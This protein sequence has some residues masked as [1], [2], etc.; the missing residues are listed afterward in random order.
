MNTIH[1]I[2]ILVF[3]GVVMFILGLWHYAI[4]LK[5]RTNI[6][7]KIQD[8][9][10]VSKPEKV[11][12]SN[13]AIKDYLMNIVNSLGKLVSSRRRGDTTH[14]RL[15]FLQA[16]YQNIN[17]PVIFFGFKAFLS[18]LLLIGF[19]LIKIIVL[20]TIAPVSFIFYSVMCALIGFYLPN[21]WLKLK[22]ANRKDK[23]QKGFPDALDLM[24]VC[25]EGGMGLDASINRIGEEMKLSNKALSEEFRLL[26]LEMR[27]GKSRREALKNLA[28]RTDVEDVNSL[29][30]LL[31]QTERFGTSIAQA[32]RVHSDFMR[33]KRYQRSEELAAKLP[34]KLIFPLIL[35][36]FPSLLITIL[37]PA[38]IVIV[39]SIFPLFPGK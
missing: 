4:Y 17:A 20:K 23:I 31:I 30:T 18:I 5:E 26:N 9:G 28:L 12:K 2:T 13:N 32:L 38:V 36:I 19:L 27:A 29:V 21:L 15:R 10:K 22:I 8:S 39:R 24:V 1:F 33:T 3:I 11:S 16:G 37:G 35:F 25:V 6:V 14:L 7:K 34:V